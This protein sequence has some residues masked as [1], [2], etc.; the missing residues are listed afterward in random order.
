MH[1]NKLK[2]L[3]DL[4]IRWHIKLLEEN[5]DKTFWHKLY[6]HLIRSVS[7]S[8]RNENKNKQMGQNQT[9]KLLY[10]KGNWKKERSNEQMNKQ[11]NRPTEWEKIAANDAT[12]KDLI[13][14]IY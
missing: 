13:S 12:N 6:K 3:K 9:Y 2:W 14:N 10:I 5:I 1:K 7:Q 4:N 11:M 8:N